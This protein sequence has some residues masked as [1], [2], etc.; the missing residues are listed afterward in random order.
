MIQ[1]QAKKE[2][3]G[4]SFQLLLLGQ[5]IS[6]LGS[7]LLRF[8]LSLYAL[9]L[10]GRAD[11]FGTL[12]ALSSI[13]LLLSPIGGA[14]ADRF[15][16]RHL[17]VIFDFASCIVVLGFL[18]LLAGGHATVVV[19]GMVMVLLSLISAMYQ[20]A[21]QASIPLLVQESRLEQANGMVNGIGALAQMAAPVLG[22]ILYGVLGLQTLMI[23]S[24]I[25]FLLS[26]V[27]QLFMEIPFVKREQKRNIV[28][29]LAADMKVGFAYVAQQRSILKAMILA[30]LLNFILTPFFVVGGP[31]IL[32]VTMH[33]SDTLYG[34]GMGIVEC[35]TILGALMIG[36]FAKK[37]QMS[38]LYRWLLIIAALI[39]P[40]SMS[41]T[42]WMLGLGYYPAYVL[43]MASVV[44]IAMALTMIS[45]F[46]L[47]RVQKQTPNDLLGKV[48]AIIMAVAQIAAPVGQI[49]YGKLFE[50]FSLQVY[51]PALL[52]FV[53]MLV[54]AWV[55]KRFYHNQIEKG[56]ED[57][58]ENVEKRYRK[59]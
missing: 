9:D 33:S 27:M 31:I 4:R 13:P 35:S 41:L 36:I 57:A 28:A 34:V 56:Q 2:L 37:M 53:A 30:A 3:F 45:I 54:M 16:R 5:I 47:T 23:G 32:R 40:L 17:I 8:G 59:E 20:P 14:I 55:T 51:F 12:Y 42:P 7:A 25:A 19:I 49:V 50:T 22:G 11:I 48:M 6:I 26:A 10:T 43:F 24:G 1:S 21:V 38:S 39:L 52:M 44:P 15:N 29:T 46:V 18:F 58:R